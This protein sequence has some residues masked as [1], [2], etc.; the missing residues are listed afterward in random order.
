MS[1]KSVIPLVPFPI[2]PK[3]SFVPSFFALQRSLFDS[4]RFQSRQKRFEMAMKFLLQHFHNNF[5]QT[6]VDLCDHS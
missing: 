3:L 4:S 2:S 1:V 6:I 5:E